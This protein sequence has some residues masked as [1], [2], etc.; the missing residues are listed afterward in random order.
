MAETAVDYDGLIPNNVGLN[1]DPRLRR[2]L[3]QWHPS[4][5]D[6]WMD[7][8]PDG[9]Q[10]ADV[11]L[12]TAVGVDQEGWAKF[13]FVRMPDYRWGI[14]LAPQVEGRTIGFGAHKGEPAWQE[15]PGEYRAMLRRLVTVQGDTEPA[16]VEQQ[17][18]LGATAPSLYDLRNLFQVNV[19]EARHLWAMVYLLQKYFGRDGREEAEDLLRRRSGDR[20]S[21]RLLGAFNEATPDWLAFFM[22][23]FF[24]DRDGKMQLHAL[25]QSGFDPLSRTCRFMLTEEAHHMFIGQSGVG[26]VLEATCAAMIK[27]GIDDPYD[28]ERVRP[29]GVIDL[30][31]IQKRANMHFSLTLDLFG[32]ELSTNAANA[33]QAGLKGRYLEDQIDDDHRLTGATYPVL[34]LKDG[35]IVRE[36]VSALSALNMRLRDDYVADAQSGIERWW[37]R[38]VDRAGIDYR[39][40]LPHVAF[41]RRIGEFA[42]IEADPAGDP[43]SADEWARRR[44]EFLPSADDDAFVASLMRPVREPG[45]F[46]SW[47]APPR[48]GID[49]KPGDFTYVKLA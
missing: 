36:E 23:T 1:A 39:I 8:G 35:K 33:F 13:G 30:P 38:I 28:I 42:A 24:T 41:N 10:A 27:A 17:R 48:T 19:E 20:D 34:R 12:R 18:R 29:L 5:L 26:R 16:S 37:N 32:S 9:F 44:D 25:A 49:N 3:E 40:I 46:A 2:A 21:P 43:M 15:A 4:Y 47:I 31:T 45:K 22:F 6:W 14:L 7:R 11:Y